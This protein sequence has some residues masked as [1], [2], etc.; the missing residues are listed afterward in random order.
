MVEGTLP[1]G[2]R[3]RRAGQTVA[4]YVQNENTSFYTQTNAQSTAG[5]TVVATNIA[6]FTGVL[7]ATAN[8]TVLTDSDGDGL[9]DAWE[10]DH[11]LATNN[12]ADAVLD[13]DGDT[14]TNLEEYQAG[15]DP[16]DPL[17]YLK[18]EEIKIDGSEVAA[19]LTFYAASN[20]T[21]TV[22]CRD[23]L[24]GGGWLRV[25]DVLASVTN[26][27]VEVLHPSNGNEPQRFYR[28]VTPRLP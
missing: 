18:I 27:V 4:F 25:S 14:L 20:K 21:Y 9:P 13:A 15:T 1:M 7:S 3:W 17:N 26:R 16:D 23:V 11:M 28:L 5:Y 24:T 2:F 8:L 19:R 22:Q 10:L 12:A 6:N